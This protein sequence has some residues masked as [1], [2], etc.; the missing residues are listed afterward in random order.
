MHLSLFLLLFSYSSSHSSLFLKNKSNHS[1]EIYKKK[2]ENWRQKQKQNLKQRRKKIKRKT[3]QQKLLEYLEY[4]LNLNSNFVLDLKKIPFKKKKALL[5]HYSQKQAFNS[6]RKQAFLK[7]K[8]GYQNYK[9][10]QKI[11]LSH[12]L[13]KIQSLRKTI[14]LIEISPFETF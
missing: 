5:S 10:R 7:Y 13:K 1:Y 8:K 4:N 11:I 2:R 6:L 12:R 9:K 14:N 3:E